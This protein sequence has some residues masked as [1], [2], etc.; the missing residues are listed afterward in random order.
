MHQPRN[1]SSAVTGQ[2]CSISRGLSILLPS[3][4]STVSGDQSVEVRRELA[5]ARERQAATAEILRMISSSPMD[6]Q[7]VFAE[8]AESAARLCDAYDA[9][10]HQVDGDLLR[11]VAHHGPIRVGSTV[12][13][14]RV[15]TTGRD[16]GAWLLDRRKTDIGT[17]ITSKTR[18]PLS[19]TTCRQST[20]GSI[21]CCSAIGDRGRLG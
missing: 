17:H 11:L 12:P 19:A 5:E 20:R 10:I 3:E 8:I 18:K 7:C 15:F 4:V 2:F 9:T 14:M 21:Q 13:L 16:F 6:P 1:I